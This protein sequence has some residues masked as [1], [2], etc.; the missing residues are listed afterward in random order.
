MTKIKINKYNFLTVQ[1]ALIIA[2][3]LAPCV[4][5]AIT[6]FMLYNGEEEYFKEMVKGSALYAAA[7]LAS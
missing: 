7:Y 2:A 5:T 4:H 1:V 6:C 3:G